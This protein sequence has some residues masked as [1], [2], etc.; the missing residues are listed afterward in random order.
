[1]TENPL[2]ALI[3]MSQLIV[4]RT[5]KGQKVEIIMSVAS[6]WS[7]MGDLLNFDR[8]G[9]YVRVVAGKGRD[10][11]EICC[12]IMFRHWLEGNGEQPATWSVLIQKLEDC[13]LKVF[14]EEVKNVRLSSTG[15]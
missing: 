15:Q 12:A 10:D 7:K 14:A 11:P 2:S 6:K 13:Q 1:M 8:T 4:M 9:R 5:P 3:S